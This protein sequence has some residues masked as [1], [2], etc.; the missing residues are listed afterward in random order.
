MGRASP[1]QRHSLVFSNVPGPPAP[2]AVGGEPVLG[3]LPLYPNL[4]TQVS[5]GP[6][7]LTLTFTLNS[8]REPAYH[9]T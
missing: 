1:P 6:L 4:I 3:L 8:D 7:T 5:F 9:P 2:F